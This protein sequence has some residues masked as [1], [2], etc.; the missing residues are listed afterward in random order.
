MSMSLLVPLH[1]GAATIGLLSGF[2]ALSLR[3]GARA[4]R[5]TGNAFFISMLCMA[6]TAAYMALMKTQMINAI[7]GILTFYMV[8]TAW[9]TVKRPAG[10]P[11]SW[12]MSW[13]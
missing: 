1:V 2:A 8:A 6:S 5:L 11:G 9:L 4:H 7:V 13:L 3:K 12:N 10:R